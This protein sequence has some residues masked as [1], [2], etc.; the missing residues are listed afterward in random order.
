[1]TRSSIESKDTAQIKW[2]NH[3]H[4]CVKGISWNFGSECKSKH[5]DWIKDIRTGKF[6]QSVAIWE[7]LKL[8]MEKLTDKNTINKVA[9]NEEELKEDNVIVRHY[10]IEMKK[11]LESFGK[12]ISNLK[13]NFLKILN[14]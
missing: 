1:M 14:F 4:M 6:D 12:I 2:I 13:L 5:F 7:G 9:N 10:F 11:S 3:R 8:S